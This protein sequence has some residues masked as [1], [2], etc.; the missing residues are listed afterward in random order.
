[1]FYNPLLAAPHPDPWVIYE[2][3]WF[4]FCG[5]AQDAIYVLQAESLAD[6]R[7]AR[8]RAVWKAP[9]DGPYSQGLWAPELHHL[10]DRWLIYFAADDGDNRN[11]RMYVLESSAPLGPYAFRGKIATPDDHWAIDGTVLRHPDGSWYFVWSGWEGTEDV[12]QHLYI[13]PMDR[14]RPW[15][16]T[17]PRV[18]ISSPDYPWER[19][20]RPLVNEGPAAVVRG[21]TIYLFYSASGSWTADYCLGLLTC[22]VARPVLDAR[23]WTKHPQ[24]VFAQNA[25]AGVYGVGHASFVQDGHGQWWIVYH[26]M[27]RPDAGWS[28]RSTRIQPF[29]WSADGLPLLGTPWPVTKPLRIV[30][31]A[32]HGSLNG[33]SATGRRGR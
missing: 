7:N 15:A 4:W 18:K 17:G 10:D 24:P 28:G 30:P 9:R 26:G 14:A 5:S 23:S 13:A 32:D 16:L 25:S 1:M 20:G 33:R 31:P 27:D 3:P 19:R 21:N 8:P 11:H 29:R 22:P 2:P 6:L 12:A